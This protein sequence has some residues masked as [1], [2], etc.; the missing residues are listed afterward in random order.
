MQTLHCDDRKTFAAALE[1]AERGDCIE[2]ERLSDLAFSAAELLAAAEQMAERGL[3]FVSLQEG[4]DT[5]GGQSAD[6]FALCIA[7]LDLD[8]AHRS[9]GIERAREEGKYKGRKPIAVDEER[10]DA[11]VARW[12]EGEVSARQAMAELGLKPNT[13]YRRFKD[14]ESRQAKDEKQAAQQRK[15]RVRAEIREAKR[16][17]EPP[18]VHDVEKE[19]RRS[20]RRAEAEHEETVKQLQKDV[21]A[22]AK[23]L[24][25]QRRDE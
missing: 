6:F 15:K 18:R 23:E 24:K 4:I 1:T 9:A 14:W 13:F 20:R 25:K 7:L 11:V 2:A 21:R 12:Q 22:E 19:R 10:F 8:R 17:D 16:A 3:D 5:R